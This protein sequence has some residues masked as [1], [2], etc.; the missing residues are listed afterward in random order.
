MIFSR[1][2]TL[3]EEVQHSSGYDVRLIV[4]GDGHHYMALVQDKVNLKVTFYS[5][6]RA[7]IYPAAPLE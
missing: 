6:E 2:K 5:D 3:P 7:V 1:A 4:S